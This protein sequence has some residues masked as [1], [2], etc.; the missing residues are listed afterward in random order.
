MIMDLKTMIS[1][2]QKIREPML[3]S[4]HYQFLK[5]FHRCESAANFRKKGMKFFEAQK[6]LLIWNTRCLNV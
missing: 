5:I 3:E 4:K 2:E 6:V 1:N